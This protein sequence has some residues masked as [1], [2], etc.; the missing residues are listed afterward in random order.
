LTESATALGACA[1]DRPVVSAMAESP[2]AAA[3]TPNS[4][5]LRIILTQGMKPRSRARADVDR[6]R[7][8]GARRADEPARHATAERRA[9]NGL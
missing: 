8:A 1:P 6:E 7:G 4:A 9:Q 3:P 2:T 5:S